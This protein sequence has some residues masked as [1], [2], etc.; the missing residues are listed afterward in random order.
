MIRISLIILLL[1]ISSLFAG[2]NNELNLSD[3]KTIAVAPPRIAQIYTNPNLSDDI[4]IDLRS[5]NQIKLF[6]EFGDNLCQT[7]A[8][9]SD[10]SIEFICCDEIKLR[11]KDAKSW[12]NFNRFLSGQ[13]IV[14]KKVSR[15]FAGRLKADGAITSTLLFSYYEQPES[16][17][18]IEVYYEWNLINLMSGKSD[19]SGNYS[20]GIEITESELLSGENEYTCFEEMSERFIDDFENLFNLGSKE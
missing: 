13:T 6:E 8:E 9:K 5:E 7:L 15:L 11:L 1:F 10:G 4:D 20:R 19:T 14:N 3:Y 17:R 18:F 12:D 16:G 2:E